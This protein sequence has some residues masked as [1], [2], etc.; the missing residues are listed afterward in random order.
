MPGNGA[1]NVPLLWLKKVWG[2]CK[3]HWKFFLGI[4]IPIIISILI[5]KGNSAKVYK[6]AADIRNQQLT[7]LE[8]VHLTRNTR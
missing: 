8:K 4:S 7:T 3:I 1:D 6:K 5:R 2:W